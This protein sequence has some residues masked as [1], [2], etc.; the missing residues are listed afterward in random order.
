MCFYLGREVLFIL[1]YCLIN[2]RFWIYF[3][4]LWIYFIY[5]LKLWLVSVIFFKGF[6]GFLGEKGDR[7]FVGEVGLRGF[8]GLIGMDIVIV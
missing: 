1:C 8:L 5:V 2:K 4:K 6:F 3:N 7:G